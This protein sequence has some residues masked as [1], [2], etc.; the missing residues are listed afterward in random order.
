MPYRNMHF[1]EAGEGGHDTGFVQLHLK[2]RN[3]MEL[4]FVGSHC[5]C[6][7][8]DTVGWKVLVP[9]MPRYLGQERRLQGITNARPRVWQCG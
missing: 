2:R 9:T 6:R 7:C 1:L 8:R 3:M 4:L 5:R